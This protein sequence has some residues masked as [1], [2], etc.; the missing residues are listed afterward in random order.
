MFIAGAGLARSYFGQ[1]QLTAVKFVPHPFSQ[2]PGERLYDTGDLGRLLANGEIEF[3]GRSDFQVK[4]RGFRIE[5][6][7]IETVLVNHWCRFGTRH[8][9]N[10]LSH[11]WDDYDLNNSCL[12]ISSPKISRERFTGYLDFT[13]CQTI[14]LG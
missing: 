8:W 9:F 12:P 11:G 5:L 2:K 10:V 4:I 7:D 3:L 1:P 14:L 13:Q 6:G